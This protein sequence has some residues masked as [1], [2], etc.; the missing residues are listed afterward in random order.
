MEKTN[1]RAGMSSMMKLKAIMEF[2]LPD[3]DEKH[4]HRRGTEKTFENLM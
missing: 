4:F 1:A 3:V 2:V